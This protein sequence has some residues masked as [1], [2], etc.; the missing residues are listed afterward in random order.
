MNVPKIH[1]LLR[2]SLI[3]I[4][5][6]AAA[7][8][9]MAAQRVHHFL[10]FGGGAAVPGGNLN[11]IYNPAAIIRVG[12]GYRILRNVQL[13]TGVDIGFRAAGVKDFFESQFGPLRIRDYQYMV[14]F[15]ARLV[16]PFGE[17]GRFEFHAGGGGAYL[18]YSERTSQPFSNAGIKLDCPV[19]TA[20]SGWG[21]YGLLGGNVA[22]TGGG[23]LRF[24]GTV[25]VYR[26][27]T[28]G[29]GLGILPPGPSSDRWINSALELIFLF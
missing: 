7:V 16:L 5:V 26:A 27:T 24:G 12:Y 28:D 20:R 8:P 29:Q 17:D 11:G 14:P 10:H 2:S 21:S 4:G 1:A 19:C 9:P 15:G 3:W 13:D 18:R 23:H 22:L 6:L 25:T